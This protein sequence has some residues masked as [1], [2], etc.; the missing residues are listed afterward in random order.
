[1]RK[2]NCKETR[3]AVEAYVLEAIEPVNERARFD[4]TFDP[5][6]PVTSAF[7]VLM[8]ELDYQSAC[9][10]HA[11]KLEIMGAGVARD[12]ERAGRYDHITADNPYRVWQLFALIGSVEVWTADQRAALASWLNQTPEEA[13]RYS[14][15]QVEAQF[16]HMSASAFER[17]YDREQRAR[18]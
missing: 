15:D 2:S 13:K 3:R 7:N 9:D 1:M 8:H 11:S 10:R 6:R 18:S 5:D 17:L 12:Y 4:G 16:C 14:A